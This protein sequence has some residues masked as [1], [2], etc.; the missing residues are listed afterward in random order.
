MDPLQP[1]RRRILEEERVVG[2]LGRHIVVLVDGIECEIGHAELLPL[3]QERRPPLQNIARRQHGSRFFPVLQASVAV[4][5]A[6]MVVVLQIQREPRFSLQ[7]V[8]PFPEGALEFTQPETVIDILRHEAVREHRVELDQHVQHAPAPADIGQ[9]RFHCGKRRLA[10][11]YGPVLQR[12]LAELFKILVQVRPVFVKRQAVDRR[13]EGPSVGQVRDLGDEIDDILPEAV[14]T[15]VQPEA[16]DALDLL[17]DL[18]VVHVEIG[19]FSGKNVQIVL[20]SLIVVFP[21]KPLEL[22]V[23]VVGR[24]LLLPFKARVPPDIVVAV[25]I[26]LSLAALDEPGVLVGGV[27]DH[28]VEQHLEAQFMGSVQHSFELFQGAVVRMY[29]LII[30]DVVAIIRVGRRVDR[31]EPDAVHSE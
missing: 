5:D 19:L 11:L 18:G 23:P 13:H 29:V 7:P 21:C 25:G 22:A 10:D 26:V 3:V 17:P 6:R 14:H 2:V 30:G 8:L 31:A 15:H 16:H 9:G 4:H 1:P 12:D 20:F 27:V 24:K 28:Q